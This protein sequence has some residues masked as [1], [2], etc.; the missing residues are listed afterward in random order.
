MGRSVVSERIVP[1]VGH[2]PAGIERIRRPGYLVSARANRQGVCWASD[3]RASC[4][5]RRDDLRRSVPIAIICPRQVP[6]W[7]GAGSSCVGP[8]EPPKTVIRKTRRATAAHIVCDTGGV[9]VVAS[10]SVYTPDATKE[11]FGTFF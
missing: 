5:S 4:S 1:I 11:G 8:G 7:I 9:S 10:Y 3:S 6:R 2:V